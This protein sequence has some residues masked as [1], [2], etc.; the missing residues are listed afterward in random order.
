[1]RIR[2]KAFFLVVFLIS[3]NVISV[4]AQG[5]INIWNI[6]GEVIDLDVSRDGRYLAMSNS[7]GL[8]F[9]ST[10]SSIPLWSIPSSL[11]GLVYQV[12]VSGDGSYIVILFNNYTL[13]TSGVAYFDRDGNELWGLLWED[14]VFEMFPYPFS[15]ARLVDI[16]DNGERVVAG[17]NNW[18]FGPGPFNSALL[19]FDECTSRTGSSE[20]PT[21]FTQFP[22]EFESTVI[23]CLD[24][25][26]DGSTI[27]VGVHVSGISVSGELV[28]ASNNVPRSSILFYPDSNNPLLFDERDPVSWLELSNSRVM[29]VS[30]ADFNHSVG[31]ATISNLVN[32]LY[33][34]NDVR[35]LVNESPADWT[36]QRDFGCLDL[37]G[38]GDKVVAGTPLPFVCGIHYWENSLARAGDDEAETWTVHEGENIPDIAISDDGCII[39][40]TSTGSTVTV[41]S[42]DRAVEIQGLQVYFYDSDAHSLGEFP[43]DGW[44][45][46]LEMSGDGRI[47]AVGGG[48]IRS[49][50][51]FK[52][53]KEEP[54]GGVITPLFTSSYFL[55]AGLL[56]LLLVAVVFH[57]KFVEHE[58]LK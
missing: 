39:A 7:T 22:G 31:A 19:Y 49:L 44:D 52:L 34:W 15:T 32:T 45:M 24:M 3:I 57:Q 38:G 56:T 17:L 13:N 53:P 14:A 18:T 28:E 9:F 23:S 47:V 11:S 37:N 2:I 21:W 48:L 50:H 5:F 20:D 6:E 54:V 30:V 16:S 36:R 26:W 33:F 27:A 40:A 12:A 42:V 29:D 10:A 55:T 25:N 1:M 41:T 35:P 43:L 8:Y 4:K 58:S 51:V 46:I